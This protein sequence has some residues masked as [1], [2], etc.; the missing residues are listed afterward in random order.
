MPQGTR[1]VADNFKVG[2]EL[3]FALG[4][5]RIP[6][7]DHPLNHKHGRAP[8]LRLWGLHRDALLGIDAPV[9]LVVGVS[10]VEFKNLHRHYL[11]LCRRVGP[12][13]PARILS[14]D[15]GRQRLALF[16]LEPGRVPGACTAPA[17]AWIDAPVAGA[18]V[19]RSIPVEGWAFRQ[20]VGL[21]KVEATLD[22][23][24]VGELE[25]GLRY[26][27]LD[28]FWTGLSDPGMP[29]LRFAGRIDAQGVAPGRHWLG[30]RLHGRDG[31]VEAWPEIPV[32]IAR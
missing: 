13:P 21:A 16:R 20:G 15:H 2:A 32:E 12:L 22:G 28:R 3:G 9:L 5:P 8:Q 19:G 4:D 6:V 14:V 31:S 24:V 1:V 23:R 18:R 17:M 7:L 29:D 10:E 25:Y 26:D 11:D 27:G 30:L